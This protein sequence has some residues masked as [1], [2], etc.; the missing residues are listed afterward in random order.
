VVAKFF[1]DKGFGFVSLPGRS[2]DVFFHVSA[3]RGLTAPR[4]RDRV[5]VMLR[6]GARGLECASVSAA[7]AAAAAGA[8]AEPAAW[9]SAGESVTLPCFSMNNPFAALLAHGFKTIESRNGTM[10]RGTEGQV[11]DHRR[12]NER[13]AREDR[14]VTRPL[15]RPSS[16]VSLKRPL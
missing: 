3:L 10:F 14:C 5:R 13:R 8:P 6:E 9:E 7:D 2:K 12:S 1:D 15:K 4:P 16:R 11:R